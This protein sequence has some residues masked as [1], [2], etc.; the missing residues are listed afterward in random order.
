MSQIQHEDASFRAFCG[1]LLAR[2]QSPRTT[3]DPLERISLAQLSEQFTHCLHNG[4]TVG[5]VPFRHV[6]APCEAHVRRLSAKT[7]PAASRA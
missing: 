2:L 6:M 7:R 4:L 3:E 1:W 5:K